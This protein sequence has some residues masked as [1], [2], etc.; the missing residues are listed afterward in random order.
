MKFLV[1]LKKMAKKHPVI[2][3]KTGEY[4]KKMTTQI[5][6]EFNISNFFAA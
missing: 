3:P 5:K 4:T 6:T 2:Y 1:I